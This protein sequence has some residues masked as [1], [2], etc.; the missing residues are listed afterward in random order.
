MNDSLKVTVVKS[1]KDQGGVAIGREKHLKANPK[2]PALCPVFAVGLYTFTK[3]R[4][5]DSAVNSKFFCGSLLW[6][7]VVFTIVNCC[8][9]SYYFN[10]IVIESD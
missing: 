6:L 3:D 10:I 5:R 4:H 9:K 7:S 2:N 1:K 8:F